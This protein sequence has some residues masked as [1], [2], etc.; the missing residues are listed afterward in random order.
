[1]GEKMSR[2]G[3]GWVCA[4][5]VIFSLCSVKS[6]RADSVVFSNLGSPISFSTSTG[7]EIVPGANVATEFTPSADVAVS[8]ID[9]GIGNITGLPAGI[10]NGVNFAVYTNVSGS[11]GS[12]FGS[13]PELT[14]FMDFGSGQCVG[15]TC[16]VQT[17]KPVGSLDLQG[18]VPYWLVASAG[19]AGTD[20][21][22]NAS[23]I[24]DGGVKINQGGGLWMD[25]VDSFGGSFDVVGAVSDSGSGGSPVPEPPGALLLAV[26]FCALCAIKVRKNYFQPRMN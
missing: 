9:V 11:P 5:A 22:W 12:V 2:Y 20:A 16:T 14:S 18:G 23:N 8:Q 13:F 1:M 6:A 10:S 24:L 17:L 4:V 19:G 15:L 7:W 25:S 3:V 21:V 26:G